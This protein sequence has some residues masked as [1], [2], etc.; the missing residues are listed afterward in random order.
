MRAKLSEYILKGKIVMNLLVLLPKE[1]SAARDVAQV[2][3]Y[4][5]SRCKAQSSNPSAIKKKK[6]EF[7]DIFLLKIY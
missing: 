6:K 1:S 5:P 4:L 7:F 2:I 3:E